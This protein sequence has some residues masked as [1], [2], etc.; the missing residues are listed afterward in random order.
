ME[1]DNYS[2]EVQLWGRGGR[3]PPELQEPKNK[4]RAKIFGIFRE[5]NKL[6]KEKNHTHVFSFFYM[7]F[8]ENGGKRLLASS[9]RSVG[10]NSAPTG[11]IFMKFDIWVH[12]ENLLLKFKSHWNLTPTTGTSHEDRYTFLIISRSV[13]L[14]MR[15]VSDK[16]STENQNTHFVLDN[17]FFYRKSCRLWD[18]V[19]KYCRAGQATDDNMAQAHCVLDNSGYTHTHT[20]TLRICNTYS[21]TTMVTRIRFSVKL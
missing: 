3:G 18:N 2:P 17:F 8:R 4:I 5:E 13:L 7:S 12:F 10:N 11:W 6:K 16:S 21:T 9:C 14:I 20:H 15:N 1:C 19:E